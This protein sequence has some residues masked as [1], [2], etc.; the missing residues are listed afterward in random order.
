MVNESKAARNG[1]TPALPSLDTTLTI[2]YQDVD[3]V[4]EVQ[5]AATAWLKAHPDVMRGMPAKVAMQGFDLYGAVMSVKATLNREAD[6]RKSEIFM[7]ILI[8]IEKIV[9]ENGAFL[10][11]Q[12]GVGLPPPLQTDK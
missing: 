3:K 2:R 4:A 11:T 9:R 8:G 1:V 5:R 6:S 10:A 12:M 7:E